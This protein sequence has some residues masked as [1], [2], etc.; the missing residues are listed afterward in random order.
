MLAELALACLLW[1]R[2]GPQSAG[3]Q[4][5]TPESTPAPSPDR[6]GVSFYPLPALSAD[7]DAGLSAGVLAGLVFTDERGIQNALLSLSAGYQHLARWNAE[8]EYRTSP[9]D[10]SLLDLDGYIA[11]R[12]ENSLRLFYEDV[13]ALDGLYHARFESLDF[14]TATD[15]FFG[16][17]DSTPHSA[18]SVRT[19]NEYRAEARFGPRLSAEW[20]LEGTARWRKFRIG[21]SLIPS[22]PQTT[23]LYPQ[24][25]G[26]EG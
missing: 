13:N 15:R 12:V 10:W 16:V 23:V 22:L 4:E 14:R 1:L 19:S 24:E 17:G 26:V 8:A 21:D 6:P 25:P 3:A 20:D 9:D 2:P 7:K 11:Q 5:K 18:Q